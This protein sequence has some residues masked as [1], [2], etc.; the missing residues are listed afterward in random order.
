MNEGH[1]DRGVIVGGGLI[2]ASFLVAVLLN[3]SA[4]NE[5]P[6]VKA[7]HDLPTPCEQVM[8]APPGVAAVPDP[9]REDCERMQP[10]VLKR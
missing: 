4:N 8:K 2:A 1:M 5:A 3:R 7:P 10:S 9:V 6:P